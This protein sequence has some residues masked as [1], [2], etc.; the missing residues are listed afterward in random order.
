[1][2]SMLSAPPAGT[3]AH[4]MGAATQADPAHRPARPTRER[5]PVP[6]LHIA[7]DLA[8]PLDA[9]TGTFVVVGLRGSGKT[10][11]G[12][13][14]AEEFSPY[15]PFVVI[16]PTGVW[17]GLRT[18]ADGKGEGLPVIVL[19][20]DHGDLPLAETDGP[21]LAKLAAT[22]RYRLVL[23]LELLRKDQQRRFVAEFLETLYHVN[24]EPLH[25]FI[26]E[27]HRFAPS[28]QRDA[29]GYLPRCIGA[30]E[31]IIK[32]GRKKGLGG[33]LISQRLA[34]IN[35]D[36]RE[37][38]MTLVVHNLTGSVDLTAV[39]QWFQAQGDPPNEA[40]AL[41]A[42]PKLAP[43]EAYVM[44]PG[45][46]RF[47]G[48]V[49]V[50]RKHTFDSSATPPVG[51]KRLEPIGR[52][53]VDLSALKEQLATTIEKARAEDP[54][55]LK[56]RIAD[57]EKQLRARPSEA[58]VE[59]VV[60]RVEVPALT[61]D[62]WEELLAMKLGIQALGDT[63]VNWLPR[64]TAI[65][66]RF[67]PPDVFGTPRQAAKPRSEPVRLPIR[68]TPAAPTNTG[69][70]I[71]AEALPAPPTEQDGTAPSG[72]ERR[73]LTALAQHGPQERTRLGLLA[74]YRPDTGHFG[75]VLGALRARGLVDGTRPLAITDAGLA[76]LGPFDP[77][78]APGPELVAYWKGRISGPAAKV[79]QVLVDAYP[80]AMTRREVAEASGYRHDTG[81]FGNILGELRGLRLVVGTGELRASD[82]LFE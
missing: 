22:G 44:S 31:D 79:L 50:R 46:L 5:P 42:L 58:R 17:Y 47:F 52:A 56:A 75:N 80:A 19:G 8:L 2:P 28:Q 69:R 82:D 37:Q 41:A 7:P 60:E 33:T 1:M 64:L 34:S 29:G 45:F 24:R 38:A 26:D 13:V 16:D 25:V 63:L 55:L 81:H 39:K 21:A 23:D 53:E 72:P 65:E 9:V 36:A 54:Q 66:E 68:P 40:E 51:Q 32:L 78:P 74:G 11:T 12:V 4:T 59:T 14:L 76:A 61:A 70:A 43:G 77:L 18:S 20:G 35:T 15:A 48:R 30:V 27:A 57:L 73:I 3:A 67:R 6:E 71:A 62:E 49:K 10:S